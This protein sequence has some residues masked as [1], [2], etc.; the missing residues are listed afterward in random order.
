M[1][2]SRMSP[3][4]MGRYLVTPRVVPPLDPGFRPA[5]LARR[6]IARELERFGSYSPVSLAVESPG[7]SVCVRDTATFPDGHPDASVGHAFCERLVKFMLWSRGG[8]RIWVDGPTGVTESL[9]RHYAEDADG[10]FDSRVIG[11]TVYGKA[12]EIHAAPR[13]SFPQD[14]STASH[15]GGHLDGCRIGFDLGASDRK[16]AAKVVIGRRA[17]GYDKVARA[18]GRAIGRKNAERPR[19]RANGDDGCDLGAGGVR[20]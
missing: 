3:E 15:L 10:Q 7:G 6:E 11:Q 2:A 14:R 18:L 17:A 13:S 8:S 19:A 12:L 4:N 16:A 20:E 9:R 5:V 1:V